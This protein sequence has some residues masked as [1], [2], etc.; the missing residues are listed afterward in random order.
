LRSFASV[1]LPIGRKLVDCSVLVSNRKV[2]VSLLSKPVPDRDGRQKTDPYG[3][4]VYA[5]L[6]NCRS[7]ELSDRFSDVVIAAIREIYPTALDGASS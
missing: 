7:R 6:L 4:L 3:R 5:S 2:W 1:E